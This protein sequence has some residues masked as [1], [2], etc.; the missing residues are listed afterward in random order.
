MSISVRLTFFGIIMILGWSRLG[1]MD[2]HIIISLEYMLD[3]LCI[4]IEL[5]MGHQDIS[6]TSDAILGHI[7]PF[8]YGDDC[9]FTNML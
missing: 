8:S 9:T 4:P 7:S 3:L 6:G 2:S 1:R 5:L